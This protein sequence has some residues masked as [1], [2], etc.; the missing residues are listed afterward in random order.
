MPHFLIHD[1]VLHGIDLKTKIRILNYVYKLLK[2]SN[3]QAQYILTLNEGDV[4]SEYEEEKLLFN[5]NEHIIIR[6]EDNPEKMIF[7]KEF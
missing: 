7:K 2:T 4:M 5:L 3:N 6:Y 1:G